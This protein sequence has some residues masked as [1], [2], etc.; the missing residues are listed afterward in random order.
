MNWSWPL[1][2]QVSTVAIIIGAAIAIGYKAFIAPKP[3]P[4]QKSLDE[5]ARELEERVRY[6]PQW[7]SIYDPFY[8]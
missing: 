8:E 7:E 6:A 2:G 4:A 3:W 5:E 1:A